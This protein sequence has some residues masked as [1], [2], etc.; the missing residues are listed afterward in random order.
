MSRGTSATMGG[1]AG[2][3]PACTMTSNLS[4]ELMSSAASVALHATFDRWD[5][6][7]DDLPDG[8]YG[9]RPPRGHDPVLIPIEE[10]AYPLMACASP[11]AQGVET[12]IDC[13]VVLDPARWGE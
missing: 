5:P 13:D 10:M 12:W 6:W 3:G 8:T 11:F 9:Y 4:G 7:A 1:A 2:F